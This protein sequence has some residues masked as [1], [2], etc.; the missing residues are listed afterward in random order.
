[1]TGLKIKDSHNILTPGRQAFCF[2]FASYM[3][4]PD[5]LSECLWDFLLQLTDHHTLLT[6]PGLKCSR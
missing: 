1:M 6:R 5:S 3:T 4:N 2:E